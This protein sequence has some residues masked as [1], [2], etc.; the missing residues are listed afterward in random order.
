MNIWMAN[1]KLV[2]VLK[3]HVIPNLCWFRP[4]SYC[5][6]DNNFLPKDGKIVNFLQISQNFEKFKTFHIL[7]ILYIMTFVIPNCCPVCS[8]PYRFGD[9]NFFAKRWQNRQFSANFTKFWK[10]QNFSYFDALWSKIFVRFTLSLTVS[11]ISV[12]FVF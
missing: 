3:I 12:F 9:K 2:F 4:I 6:W 11:E 8:I 10:I 7:T 1:V 5:F